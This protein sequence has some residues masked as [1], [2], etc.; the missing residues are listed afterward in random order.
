[1]HEVR[2]F[3]QT[4]R[5][6]LSQKPDVP[7]RFVAT[8]ARPFVRYIAHPEPV[9]NRQIFAQWADLMTAW[10]AAWAGAAAGGTATVELKAPPLRDAGASKSFPTAPDLFATTV[11]PVVKEYCARC[12]APSAANSQSPFFASADV[13]EAYAAAR[14]KI[15]LDSP[16]ASRLVIQAA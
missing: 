13:N 10:I 1:M 2:Q 11:H 7:V 16:E 3:K 15:N 5:D 14:V 6:A 4:L 12:H 8:G 9:A